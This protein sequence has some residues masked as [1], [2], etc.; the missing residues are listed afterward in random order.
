MIVGQR[1][2]Q[3]GRKILRRIAKANGYEYPKG[4]LAVMQ[5]EGREE[6]EERKKT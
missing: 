2:G 4:T 6:E 3:R 1:E 5:R